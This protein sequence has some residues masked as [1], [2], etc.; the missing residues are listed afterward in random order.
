MKDVTSNNEKTSNDNENNS[1]IVKAGLLFL[2]VL[3]CMFSARYIVAL[4]MLIAGMKTDAQTMTS[5]L[6]STVGMVVGQVILFLPTIIF[7]IIGKGRQLKKIRIKK[8]KLL[9][10]LLIPL[11][12]YSLMPVAN[13]LDNLV[14]LFIKSDIV[15]TVDNILGES[16]PFVGFLVVAVVPAIF[17][18]ITYR[19]CIYNNIKRIGLLKASLLCGL[20]FGFAHGNFNQFSYAFVL[21][22][23]FCLIVEATDSL[24]SSSYMHVILN[25]TSFFSMYMLKKT[26]NNLPAVAGQKLTLQNFMILIPMAIV[27]LAFACFLYYVIALY[28]GRLEYIKEKLL[29]KNTSRDKKSSKIEDFIPIIIGCVLMFLIMILEIIK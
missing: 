28:S 19:G 18:E 5:F 4:V 12:T 11:F 9:N 25:G 15:N 2:G 7:L 26:K 21:G 29:N 17:E 27:G 8:M 22:V 23:V 1:E 24:L 3:M 10:I 14:K 13:I 6:S 20:M 16:S